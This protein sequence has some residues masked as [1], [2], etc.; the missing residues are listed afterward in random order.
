LPRC[1]PPCSVS[2]IHLEQRSILQNYASSSKTAPPGATTQGPAA[3]ALLEGAAHDAETEDAAEALE[4]AAAVRV[5]PPRPSNWSTMTKINAGTGNGRTGTSRDFPD[6]QKALKM[7]KKGLN[8]RKR[9][10]PFCCVEALFQSSSVLPPSG[11]FLSVRPHGAQSQLAPF[12]P[13]TA[14]CGIQQ[15]KSPRNPQRPI[16][17]RRD[18]NFNRAVQRI[19]GMAHGKTPLLWLRVIILQCKGCPIF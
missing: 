12:P 15:G 1:A 18:F 17:P 6:V 13:I 7:S 5:K 14:P 8:G 3:E 4:A 2:H 11:F 10:F 9:P 16:N 19:I